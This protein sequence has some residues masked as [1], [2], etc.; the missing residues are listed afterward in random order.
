MHKRYFTRCLVWI[1]NRNHTLLQNTNY[2]YVKTMLQG[3]SLDLKEENGVLGDNYKEE[4][5]TTL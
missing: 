5:L 4:P 2:N 3:I 1:Q